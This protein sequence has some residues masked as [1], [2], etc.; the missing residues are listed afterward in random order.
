MKNAFICFM[1][2]ISTLSF[3]SA[4]FTED[5]PQAMEQ[6]AEHENA[7]S[8]RS[9]DN[10]QSF[11]ENLPKDPV[12]STL[13]KKKTRKEKHKADKKRAPKKA[14]KHKNNKSKQKKKTPIIK[15]QGA[16]I[17]ALSSSSQDAEAELPSENSSNS[18]EDSE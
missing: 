13:K 7:P 8:N 18:S 3:C 2:G 12:K 5:A 15:E 6:D 14:K 1:V 17:K 9:A 10:N 16:Q 11:E 4:A